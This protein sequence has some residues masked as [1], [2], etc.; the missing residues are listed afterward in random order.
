MNANRFPRGCRWPAL[1]VLLGGI[2]LLPRV[3]APAADHRDGPIFVNTQ[4]NGQQD[5]NDIYVFRSPSNASNTVF[6][7]TQQP[8][9][10][11]ITPPTYDPTTIFDI[12]IDTNGDGI[13]DI[14]FRTTFGPPDAMGVQDV[15]MRALPSTKFPPT[16]IVA[17]G[18]TGKNIP[19]TGGGM[20][21]AAIQD[22]PFFF[23]AGAFG[24][25]VA[26]GAPG[27]FPRPPAT[28]HNFFG[29]NGNTMAIV[30]EIP[31]VRIAPSNAV[32]G[33]FITSTKNNVQV[34][35]M[36]RPAINTALIPPVPRNSPRGERRNA[37]NAGL[38]RN[39]LRDFKAD[40][41][42]VLENFFGRSAADSNFL[43]AALLPDM[44]LFQIGNPGGFGTLIGPGPGI[45]TGPFAGGQVLGN[46]RRLSDDVIDIEVNLLTNGA[47]PGDNVGDDNGLRVTD[48]SVDPVSM[49]TRMIAFPY[50]GP[51]NTPLNGP[52]TGPNP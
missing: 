24:Q 13:E 18:K 25:F 28:A 14:T 3:A 29:P 23:D 20:F 7:F 15:T 44:L 1:A 10:G 49:Q 42:F 47:I 35:R 46:G 40:M 4:M 48:G 9:P 43:T 27:F 38:P 6:V 31:S 2:A 33:V 5:L 19:V 11:N 39:D 16:G 26:A 50:I 36:G 8:F 32:I 51:A 52:G 45:F 37:F 12:K 22:D 34:D 17:R 21:R 41:V 30:L